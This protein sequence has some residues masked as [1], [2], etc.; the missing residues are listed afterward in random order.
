MWNKWQDWDVL[1]L[2]LFFWQQGT[3]RS[4]WA[5]LAPI[6]QSLLRAPIRQMP[7]FAVMDG[8]RT[9]WMARHRISVF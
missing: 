4:K 7:R 6:F 1:V 2:F 3:T 8:P 9:S 5:L